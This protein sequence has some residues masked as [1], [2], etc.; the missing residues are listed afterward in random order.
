MRR[1]VASSRQGSTQKRQLSCSEHCIIYNND[2]SVNKT[3]VI[4]CQKQCYTGHLFRFQV[5]IQHGSSYVSLPYNHIDTILWL[6]IDF[7]DK[8]YNNETRKGS[9]WHQERTAKKWKLLISSSFTKV[10]ED[11][12]FGRIL[13]LPWL[14]RRGFFL[15]PVRLPLLRVEEAVEAV[16][17]EAFCPVGLV[18]ECPSVPV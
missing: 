1:I 7:G 9:P 12:Y 14:K 5:Y 16:C 3:G 10:A 18:P 11:P 8:V 13:T 6:S 2:F 17:P 4:T 15:H